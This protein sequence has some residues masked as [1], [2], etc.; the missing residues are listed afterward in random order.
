MISVSL[1]QITVEK[2]ENGWLVVWT[3]PTTDE[4]RKKSS[5]QRKQVAKIASTQKQ[6][7]AV[8]KE[9]SDALG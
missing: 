3:R 7:L 9:A 8:I 2:V 4:E 1:P 5:E 6:L